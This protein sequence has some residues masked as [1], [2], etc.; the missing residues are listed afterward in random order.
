VSP[1]LALLSSLGLDDQVVIA[2]F[3]DNILVKVRTDAPSLLTTMSLGEMVDFENLTDE[4]ETTYTPPAPLI[5]AP[6]DRVTDETLARARRHHLAV[7]AWTVDDEAT[8]HDLLGR[9]VDGIVTNAPDLLQA[10]IGSS[11]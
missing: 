6:V 2:S 4:E 10:V 5:Q 3:Y 7:Q 8:M 1:V 11:P 9:G